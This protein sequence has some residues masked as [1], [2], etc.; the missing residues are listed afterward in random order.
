MGESGLK[1]PPLLA[2]AAGFQLITWDGTCEGGGSPHLQ[3]C[4]RP[5]FKAREK[6]TSKG[7]AGWPHLQKCL[8]SAERHTW[9]WGL[10]HVRECH[11][12]WL[13]E[14]GSVSDLPRLP[15][16]LHSTWTSGCPKHY[17]MLR[18]NF[19]DQAPSLVRTEHDT[20]T[21][22][23]HSIVFLVFITFHQNGK[24]YQG[25]VNQS[26][27]K[28]LTTCLSGWLQMNHSHRSYLWQLP[29][30]H[31]FVYQ[32]SMYLGVLTHSKCGYWG[33]KCIRW[34]K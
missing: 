30:P 3:K 24:Y 7:G 9:R 13:K 26:V 32:N 8:R 2:A 11:P 33:G 4:L 29:P 16:S 5:G 23:V 17:H 27:C 28:N 20:R 34:K 14:G 21:G 19:G 15:P 10:P 31:L 6:G 1:D 12:N 25:R 22:L 18:V